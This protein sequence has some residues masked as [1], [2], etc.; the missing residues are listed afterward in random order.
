MSTMHSI[1]RHAQRAGLTVLVLALLGLGAPAY[2]AG[3]PDGADAASAADRLPG[4]AQVTE[5]QRATLDSQIADRLSS[6]RGGTRIS[7][8]QISWH[9]GG[10][11]LTLP[12]PGESRARDLTASRVANGPCAYERVCLWS[13]F[14]KSGEK[15]SFYTC[16]YRKLRHYDFTNRTT[17]WENHQSGRTLT[18]LDYWTGS[19]TKPLD[20]LSVGSWRDF[21]GTS[22]DNR[23]DFLKVCV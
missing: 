8:N 20:A 15:L 12:L 19:R 7:V 1:T 9:D 2:S 4:A 6:T 10:V 11:V 18:R 5:A 16:A 17:T 3:D 23:A 21:S 14:Q 22:R 13:G